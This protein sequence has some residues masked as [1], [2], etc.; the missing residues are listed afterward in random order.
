MT[1]LVRCL[2]SRRG[3]VVVGR[4]RHHSAPQTCRRLGPKYFDELCSLWLRSEL[5]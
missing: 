3:H 2:M 4:Q 1:S 5:E